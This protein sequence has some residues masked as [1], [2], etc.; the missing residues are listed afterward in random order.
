MDLTLRRQPQGRRPRAEALR[1]AALPVG[2]LGGAAAL[3][4]G[5]LLVLSDLVARLG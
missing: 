4:V 2:V 3:S 5:V 1:A